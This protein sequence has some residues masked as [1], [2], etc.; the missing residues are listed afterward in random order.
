MNSR[1]SWTFSSEHPVA[2]LR[3]NQ[4]PHS[5]VNILSANVHLKYRYAHGPLWDVVWES[6]R[7][8]LSRAIARAWGG[9]YGP[10]AS[11]A[12]RLPQD[13]EDWIWA[14]IGI[15]R[16]KK[17]SYKKKQWRPPSKK[18]N[19]G[20]NLSPRNMKACHSINI[21]TVSQGVKR[22]MFYQYAIVLTFIDCRTT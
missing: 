10:T 22:H 8:D 19:R 16:C 3:V 5:K 9:C 7:V 11:I 18:K 21:A 14:I 1:I 2:A 15:S 20:R 13:D 4:V 6:S 17:N 12:P